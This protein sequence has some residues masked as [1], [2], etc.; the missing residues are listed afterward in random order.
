MIRLIDAKY[1][2][3]SLTVYE[4][5]DEDT[6]VFRGSEDYSTADKPKYTTTLIRLNRKQAMEVL[7]ACANFINSHPK[8]TD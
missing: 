2:E 7:L 6:L 1:P 8:E 3:D 5:D 4:Q